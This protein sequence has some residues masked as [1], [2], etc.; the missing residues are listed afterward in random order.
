[1]T[2]LHQAGILP[3]E[4]LILRVAMG[5]DKFTGVLRPGQV[6]NLGEQEIVNDNASSINSIHS[7]LNV[8]YYSMHLFQAHNAMQ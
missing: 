6:T 3:D 5:G 4:D 8:Q 1:M 7:S 2:D